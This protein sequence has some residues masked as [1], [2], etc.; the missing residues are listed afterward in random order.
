VSVSS[1]SLAAVHAALGDRD[2]AFEVLD[3]AV[4][5]R[6]TLL[7]FVKADPFL[8][9]L[10]GDPRWPALLRRLNFPAG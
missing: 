3:R 7:G 6:S 4:E 9:S 1:Y 2:K 10:H 5:E 8:E